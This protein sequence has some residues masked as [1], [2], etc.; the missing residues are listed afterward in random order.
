M[1]QYLSLLISLLLLANC[2]TDSN[3][4]YVK[5]NIPPDLDDPTVIKALEKDAKNLNR[6]F[7]S[8]EDCADTFIGLVDTMTDITEETAPRELALQYAKH[9]KKFA[10]KMTKLTFN[11]TYLVAEENFKNKSVQEIVKELSDNERK[12]YTKTIKHLSLKKEEL[13]KKGE[14]F[15]ARIDSLQPQME[16]ATKIMEKWNKENE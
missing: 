15:M 12:V 11:M 14:E 1:K 8:L 7:N 9:S 10:W 6:I 13:E 5:L 16:R 4:D 2:G 3:T